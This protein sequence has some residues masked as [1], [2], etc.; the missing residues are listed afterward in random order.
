[1]YFSNN[2]YRVLGIL[3]NTGLKDIQKNLSKL[4]AFSKIGKEMELDYNLSFLNLAKI[5]RTDDLLLKSENQLNLDKDKIINS[6]FWF[7][8]L[9]P[10]DSVA[11]ANLVKGD[12]SKAIEIWDKSSTSKEVSLKNFSAFNNL[13]TLLLLNT[14]DDSK[15][16]TFKK[17]TDSIK[18][19][20][21][22][23]KLKNEFISSPFFKNH[24]EAISKS[25]P[26][27]SDDAQEFFT[28]TIL[29]LFNKN[30]SIKEL[31]DLFEGLD[32]KLK[33]TLNSSLTEVPFSNIKSHIENASNLVEK[34]KKSGIKVGKQ[35]IKDTVKDIKYLKEI[36]SSDD[37]QF[38]SIS[39]KLSNQILQCGIVCFNE[40]GDDQEYLSSYEYAYS[41]AHGEKTKNR[42]KDCIKHCKEEKD[43][44]VCKFCNLEN[45][46][47]SFRVQISKE[48]FDGS[49]NYFKNGGLE[50]SCCK[51][52]YK[53]IYF[54]K[55]GSAFIG[56][57]IYVS[58][59]II[60]SGVLIFI[61][62][63]WGRFMILKWFTKLIRKLIFFNNVKNHPN[64]IKLTSQ[65]YEF[66]KPN[67]PVW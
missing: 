15:T 3:S 12:I 64:I 45:I 65:D 46:S 47:N 49:Y 35:L 7:V 54:R 60:T 24:C 28:N 53:G 37:F 26:I 2:P 48:S 33:D 8:N 11:L 62:L 67:S 10:I 25:T 61:D 21:K 29:D 50:I 38:Q 19:V 18:Q 63:F 32:D 40:T 52:C 43:A 30:F 41:L 23:I 1:M 6:L 59:G 56:Y 55:Y 27:S 57:V 44:N 14:L 9:N 51:S 58:I 31:S 42:A 36:S 5:D 39:D 13:S 20:S 4:K 16:D 34:N 22:A 66:G 17:D